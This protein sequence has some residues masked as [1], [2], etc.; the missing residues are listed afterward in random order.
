MQEQNSLQTL[1][2]EFSAGDKGAF[3]LSLS[4]LVAAFA[5]NAV[6][7]EGQELAT[8]YEEAYTANV[9]AMVRAKALSRARQAELDT[10]DLGDLDA[11]M[12]ALES[13]EKE[14]Q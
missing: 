14:L 9:M 3:Y 7:L 11:E 12:S 10:V 2:S 5:V 13:A 1:F 6:W 4:V 8:D